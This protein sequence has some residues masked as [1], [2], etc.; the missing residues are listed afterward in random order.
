MMF[1]V[2]DVCSA[3]NC[4]QMST[5]ANERLKANQYLDQVRSS[6]MAWHT[7]LS[8]FYQGNSDVSKFFGL[9]LARDFLRGRSNE[10]NFEHLQEIR[11]S[12]IS[13]VR[14]AVASNDQAVN[15]LFKTSMNI[16]ALLIKLEYPEKWENPFGELLEIGKLGFALRGVEF[17][18][19][20]LN[21]ID[22]EIVQ[23][24][25][26][27]DKTS[28]LQAT[29][30][31]DAMRARRVTNELVSFLC[32]AAVRAKNQ[33]Q[34]HIASRCL[35]SLSRLIVWVDI[36]LIVNNETLP[37]IYSGLR[38]EEIAAGACMCV[39]EMVKKGMASNHKLEL[40]EKTDVISVLTDICNNL[41]NDLAEDVAPLIDTLFQEVQDIWADVE[42]SL[43]SEYREKQKNND[44]NSN[45]TND[46]GLGSSSSSGKKGKSSKSKDK[47]DPLIRSVLVTKLTSVAF[48]MHSCISMSLT[49]FRHSDSDVSSSLVPSLNRFVQLLRSQA[50]ASPQ[51]KTN[52]KISKNASTTA[53]NENTGSSGNNHN[54]NH[55]N[56]NNNNRNRSRSNSNSNS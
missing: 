29:K 7:G 28:F 22:A 32:V 13:W 43:R 48:C 25:D 21:D 26:K 45:S 55:N 14:E 51:S 19:G 42:Q 53:S 11:L 2:S 5:D 17:V 12:I 10:L 6:Q 50:N 47:L 38:D 35:Q 52:N 9:S 23:I 18:M 8:L 15:Y 3:V 20:V 40:I 37:L 16:I 27:M 1:N 56:N 4:A 24:H 39:Q 30:I 44:I 33:G 31:K 46:M 49:L 36:S 54:H 41:S 34:V